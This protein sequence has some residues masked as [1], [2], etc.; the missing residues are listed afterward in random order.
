[1]K[2]TS[3]TI[4]AE[5]KII[6]RRG[7]RHP[8]K[9]ID[10]SQTSFSVMFTGSA[11]G[12]L[13]PPYMVYRAEN[14]YNSWTE[15]GPEGTRYNQSKN[16]WFNMAIFKDYFYSLVLPYFKR[17]DDAL[18]KKYNIRFMLMPP[19]STHLCQ[20][21]DV[22]FFRPL[23][24]KWAE[25]LHK[26]KTTH[27]GT[28]PKDHFPRL[29]K[30]CLDSLNQNG[31]AEKNLKAG[32][33][34]SGIYPI[35]KNEVLKRIPTNEGAE[36]EDG[37]P[38]I[39]KEAFTNFLKESRATETQPLRKRKKKLNIAPGKSIDSS[40]LSDIQQEEFESATTSS[41]KRKEQQLLQLQRIRKDIRKLYQVLMKVMEP[42]H[43]MKFWVG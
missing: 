13:L 4:L 16:S 2:Q 43:Y 27:R 26:W 25:V 31:S 33:K 1:M 39:W 36:S 34:G 38:Q 35:N 30:S 41:E 6:A 11:S 23:K 21:L 3:P 22:A 8:E 20:P 40:I 24:V 10:H 14:M 37:N 42:F 5:K 32:F 17:F 9:I 19:N 15:G 28:I 12:H 7:C 18:P 29:L